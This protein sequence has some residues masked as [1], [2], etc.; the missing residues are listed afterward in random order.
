MTPE[1]YRQKWSLPVDYPMVA[2]EYS[3]KRSELAKSMN[4][5]GKVRGGGRRKA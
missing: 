1:D 3:R 4:L 5:G 2:P